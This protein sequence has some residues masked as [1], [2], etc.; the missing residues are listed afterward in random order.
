MASQKAYKNIVKTTFL[1]S[2]VKI[3]NILMQLGLNKIVAVLL[4]TSGMGLIGL[5]RS[6]LMTVQTFA[7]LGIPQSSIKDISESKNSNDSEKLNMTLSVTK[8]IVLLTAI[9]GF[10]IVF[11]LAPLLS[12]WTFNSNEYTTEYRWLAISAFFMIYGEGLRGLL[13]GMRNLKELAKASV[14]GALFGLLTGAPLYYAYG[15][16]GIVPSLVVSA[17]VTF[18]VAFYYSNKI[19]FKRIK[20]KFTCYFSEGKSMIVM[21]IGLMYVGLASTV[22]DYIIK[23]YISTN[24]SFEIVG[25]F[26]AGVTILSSYF[27]IVLTAMTTDYYPRIAGIN[28]DNVKL[29]EEV[30]KQ[31][32]V[33]LLMM[34]PLIM[35]FV[36]GL[37]FFLKILYSIDF[38]ES[39]EYIKYALFGFIITI[40]SNAMGMILIAKQKTKIFVLSVTVQRILGVIINILF[41]KY[42]GLV[43]LGISY[44]ITS[45]IHL[46]LMQGIMYRFQII[47]NKK[48]LMLLGGILSTLFISLL[49]NYLEPPFF[50]YS[51][52]IILTFIVSIYCF[53]RLSS[54]MDINVINIIKSKIKNGKN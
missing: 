12:Q 44:I 30:N 29:N 35:V 47:F 1:F 25:L 28:K 16:N 6:S 4:G 31:S 41:F 21:G 19:Q 37:P 27:G 50:K 9:F 49:L 46:L 10:L 14:F 13:T 7:G 5:F 51:F 32:E 22:S 23:S 11:V 38:V 40:C 26:T 17:F 54:E 15:I 53:N 45:F 36:I 52:Q 42:Y 24:S 43:G 3:F 33:G 8:V 39:Q 2:F 18:S 48:L 34:S 20:L